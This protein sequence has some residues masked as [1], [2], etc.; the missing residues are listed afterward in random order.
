MFNENNTPSSV[1]ATSSHTA[2]F[3]P[4][5]APEEFWAL[6]TTQLHHLY[7]NQAQLPE[8]TSCCTGWQGGRENEQ[9]AKLHESLTHKSP[10]FLLYSQCFLQTAKNSSRAITAPSPIHG[11]L[12][13]E[14][15]LQGIWE[16]GTG[17]TPLSSGTSVKLQR[18]EV[19]N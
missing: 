10:I 13:M 17:K 16:N 11:A 6:C 14:I 3:D 4:S 18:P 7:A 8:M 2:P 9:C 19:W 15:Q 5:T 12:G 1:S